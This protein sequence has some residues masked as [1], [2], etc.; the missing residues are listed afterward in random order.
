MLYYDRIDI[1]EGID[2][3]KTTAPKECDA[4]HYWLCHYLLNH[5]FKFQPNA[6]NRCHN[7]LMM[8]RKLSNFAILNIKGSDYCCIISLMIKNEAMNYLQNTNST[9]KEEHYKKKYGELWI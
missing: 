6:C 8:P 2:V 5:S 9:E 1:F 7:L 3:N 4:C